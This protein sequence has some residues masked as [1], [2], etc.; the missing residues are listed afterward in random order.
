M[1][2]TNNYRDLMARETE[3]KEVKW[4]W[5]HGDSLW[6]HITRNLAR[7]RLPHDDRHVS[8]GLRSFALA[9]GEALQE[10]CEN[11]EALLNLYP[12]NAMRYAFIS[13][14]DLVGTRA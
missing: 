10:S 1:E 9:M 2:A 6:S 13:V 12:H 5:A 4:K 7:A 8:Y 3:A 14:R 11:G